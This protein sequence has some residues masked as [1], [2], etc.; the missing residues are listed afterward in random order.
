MPKATLIFLLFFPITAFAQSD[1]IPV[2]Q[3]DSLT[4]KELFFAGLSEKLM[5]NYEASTVSF[6]KVLALDKANDAAL[7]EMANA[8]LRLNH[9]IEAT[10]Y[11]K[12]AADL[13][14]NNK[15]Y[16]ELLAKTYKEGNNI[17]ELVSLLNQ[18]I[19]LDPENR[20]YYFDKANAEL[21]TNKKDE[22]KATYQL[23]EQKF[24]ASPELRNAKSRLTQ[25]NESKSD[26]VKLLDNNNAN[27]KDYLYAAGLLMQKGDNA[28]A[29]EV[30]QKIEKL[31]PNNYEI[32]LALADAYRKQG[33]SARSFDALKAAFAIEEMPITD[34]IQIVGS[35]FSK[36]GDV[37]MA[38][39]ISTLAEMLVKQNPADAKILALYG[40]VLFR[41]DKFTEALKQYQQA[42]K[43]NDQVFNVWEGLINTHNLLNQFAEAIRVSEEALTIY[44]NQASLYYFL[45]YAQY[46]SKLPDD[47]LKNL[48]NAVSLA[49]EDHSLLAQCYTLKADIL[50]DKNNFDGAKTSFAE[51]IKQEPDNYQIIT[52]AAY[53]LAL[54]DEDLDTA[55]KYAESAAKA[56]PENPAI[57]DTYAFV[58]FKQ[59][60]YTLAKQWIER[61]LQNKKTNN[62]VY[63]EHYGDILSL[64]GDKEKALQQWQLARDAG[65]TSKGL[66]KKINEKKYI[67]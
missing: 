45:A 21:L 10:R 24:G 6:A 48:T 17:A 20:A 23:I 4:V 39:N 49:A 34:K 18:L 26:I 7:Y 46:R 2:A 62:G 50:I 29:V 66:S 32:K 16:L 30:L 13:K 27:P 42:L 22:A 31:A 11:A 56:K 58:L 67:K 28:K 9:L 47:A 44:P 53:F 59:K 63:L 64:L 1:L 52:K 60:K 61:T 14:P 54:R 12:G 5:G 65:N 25:S 51:A 36:T 15:Y 3:R 38:Q 8:N 33:Q 37:Q 43:L 35:L 57:T 40:D 19:K 41:Q 55:E